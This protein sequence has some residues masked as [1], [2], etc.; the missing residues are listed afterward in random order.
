MKTHAVDSPKVMRLCNDAVNRKGYLRCLL[1]LAS[2]RAAGLGTLDARGLVRYYQC[3]L[4]SPKPGDVPLGAAGVRYGRILDAVR[5]AGG[6]VPVEEAASAAELEDGEVDADGPRE[7]AGALEVCRPGRLVF[8]GPS[9][10]RAAGAGAVVLK[11][12]RVEEEDWRALLGLQD[13]M[14]V[15]GDVGGG[16]GRA[17]GRPAGPVEVLPL[18]DAPGPVVAPPPMAAASSGEAA[19]QGRRRGRRGPARVGTMLLE[20]VELTPDGHGGAGRPGSYRRMKCKCPLH[21]HCKKSRVFSEQYG[22]S[23][24]LGDQEP[25]AY[26]GAWLRGRTHADRQVGKSHKTWNPSRDEVLE[27]ARTVLGLVPG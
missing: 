24:G 6:A 9:R 11:R 5:Q 4:A 19:V 23:T 12:R 20:G 7:E 18:Q 27:Y 14:E 22:R 10:K 21:S 3:V 16:D 1:G 25:Y 15:D 26:L 2:L 8:G 17:V 13:A